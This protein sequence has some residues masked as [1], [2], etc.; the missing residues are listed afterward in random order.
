MMLNH[1]NL[2]P[3][4]LTLLPVL[5]LCLAS[6]VRAQATGARAIERQNDKAWP[7]YRHDNQRTGSSGAAITFPLQPLWTHEPQHAPVPAWGGPA[8]SDLYNKVENMRMR[9]GFDRAFH[10]TI[11][12]GRV[13]FASSA[14][15]QVHCLDQETGEEL[16]TFFAEAPIR[17]AP[18]LWQDRVYFGSDDGHAY[19]VLAKS[20]DQVWRVRPGPKDYRIPGNGRMMS[21]WPVRTG[22]VIQD[23]IA[24]CCAG[25]F[26]DAGS[27]LCAIKARTGKVIWTKKAADI[28]AQ[29]YML[30]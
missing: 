7:T 22:V 27:Y 10:T 25:L 4:S 26:P 11:A 9:L 16:W 15:D 2:Q 28:H 14:D 21:A 30:A 3:H 13:F 8:K 12:K 5:L 19:C 18:T 29:G 17:F 6:A 1:P 24:Y 20:G 23:E